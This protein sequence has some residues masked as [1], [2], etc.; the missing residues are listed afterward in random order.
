[1]PQVK[2]KTGETLEVPIDDLI[3]FLEKRGDEILEQKG[4]R[5]SVPDLNDFPFSCTESPLP[6]LP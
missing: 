5:L 2:L 1:M 3:E 4:T 6:I